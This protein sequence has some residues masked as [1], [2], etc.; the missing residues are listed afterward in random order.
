MQQTG[1]EQLMFPLNIDGE[2]API[3]TKAPGIGEHTD[4]VLQRV[5]GYESQRLAALHESG[6]LG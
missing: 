5:L 3:P 6:A 1:C 2:E 4:A